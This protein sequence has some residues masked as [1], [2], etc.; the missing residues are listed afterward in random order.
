VREIRK[1]IN[2]E[3]KGSKK[4]G[5]KKKGFLGKIGLKADCSLL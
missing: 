2:G 1:E 5:T 3:G 4:P